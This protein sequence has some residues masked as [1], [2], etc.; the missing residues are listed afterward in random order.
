MGFG[1][2]GNGQ[3]SRRVDEEN[4]CDI[5]IRALELGIIC[6]DTEIADQY[7]VS[8]TEISLAWLFTKI[9]APAGGAMRTSHIEGAAKAVGLT[10]TVDELGT[11]YSS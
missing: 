6:F 2:A 1:E 7:G 10:L 4:S 9:T 11:I 3:H 5:I 8:M